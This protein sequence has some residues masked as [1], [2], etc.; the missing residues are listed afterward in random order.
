MFSI[1]WSI[2]NMVFCLCTSSSTWL[3]EYLP[4]NEIMMGLLKKEG[5]K[6]AISQIKEKLHDINNDRLK[7]KQ[8]F[9]TPKTWV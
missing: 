4:T 1:E 3:G 9:Y 5:G 7:N 6:E 8:S 2:D